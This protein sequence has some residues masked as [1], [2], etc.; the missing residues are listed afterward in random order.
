MKWKLVV[1]CSLLS[2]PCSS[3]RNSI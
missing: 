1:L 3:F 2:S